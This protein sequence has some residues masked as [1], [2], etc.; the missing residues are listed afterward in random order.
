MPRS[1]MGHRKDGNHAEIVQQCRGAGMFVLDTAQYGASVDIMVVHRQITA[2]VEIKDA[3]KATKKQ[4]ENPIMMLTDEELDMCNS[5]MEKG[6]C[7][8][9]AFDVQDIIDGVEEWLST[10]RLG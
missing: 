5:V 8:V 10:Q 4:K 3:R 1:Y 9:I 2:W 6:G 7:Y